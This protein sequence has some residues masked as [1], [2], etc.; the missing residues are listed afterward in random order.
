[1]LTVMTMVVYIVKRLA[2]SVD[3]VT[4]KLDVFMSRVRAE[5]EAFMKNEI[6]YDH[7]LYELLKKDYKNGE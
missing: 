5:H 4:T 3:S 2:S 7:M 1:M 6:W